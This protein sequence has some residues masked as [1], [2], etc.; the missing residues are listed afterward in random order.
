MSEPTIE[1]ETDT[2][3]S[4]YEEHE[5]H[6][7]HFHHALE[8]VDIDFRLFGTNGGVVF[9]AS[10]ETKKHFDMV[11]FTMSDEMALEV[12]LKIIGIVESRRK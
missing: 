9:E 10:Q 4:N 1:R 12:A 8:H 5:T 11:G 2:Y 3:W 7:I 6:S